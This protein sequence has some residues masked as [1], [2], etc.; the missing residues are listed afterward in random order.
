MTSLSQICCFSQI[1]TQTGMMILPPLS[2]PFGGQVTYINSARLD[3][4]MHHRSAIHK[5]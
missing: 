3:D 4:Q 5:Q 1:P 2:L